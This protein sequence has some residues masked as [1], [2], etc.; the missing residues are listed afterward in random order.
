MA[1]KAPILNRH[2]G[3]LQVEGYLRQRDVV[4]LFVESKPQLAGR[5]VKDRVA[6]AAR[7]SV[8]R[9][10]VVRQPDA[11]KSGR[12]NQG[13]EQDEGDPVRPPAGT[14]QAQRRAP[15]I[16][17]AYTYATTKITTMRPSEMVLGISK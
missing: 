3:V 6:D 11:R 13:Q 8:D 12:P 4:A 16:R 7:Q 10:R 5:V 9:D 14:E 2:H 17:L 1:V 15:S